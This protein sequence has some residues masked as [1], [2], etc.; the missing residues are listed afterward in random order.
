MKQTV[1]PQHLRGRHLEEPIELFFHELEGAL[2]LIPYEHCPIAVVCAP[3]TADVSQGVKDGADFKFDVKLWTIPWARVC[4]RR[5]KAIT[6]PL[7][8]KRVRVE[9]EVT[10]PSVLGTSEP[11]S[12]FVLSPNSG[13]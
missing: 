3:R 8:A 5:F 9:P 4:L 13:R 1:V 10:P 12:D 6:E 7:S 2:A 11:I